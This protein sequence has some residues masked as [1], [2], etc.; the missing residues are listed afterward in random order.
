LAAV[1][2]CSQ[3]NPMLQA[4]TRF[5]NS[6]AIFPALPFETPT[7][8]PLTWTYCALLPDDGDRL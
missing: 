6:A 4:A 2:L 7:L 1:A 5:S 8:R 3:I